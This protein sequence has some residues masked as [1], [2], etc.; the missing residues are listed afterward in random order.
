M[1]HL[2]RWEKKKK[3]SN[4]LIVGKDRIIDFQRRLAFPNSSRLPLT[5]LSLLT[6]SVC[7]HPLFP[8][9]NNFV[10]LLSA[11]KPDTITDWKTASRRVHHIYRSSGE[12]TVQLEVVVYR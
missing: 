7:I 6:E 2:L 4:S 12:T 10:K 5:V 11:L 9:M 3:S 8:S 1:E